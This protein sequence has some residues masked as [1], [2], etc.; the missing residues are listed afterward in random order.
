MARL[1]YPPVPN[2]GSLTVAT[3]TCGCTE[4]YYQPSPERIKDASGDPSNPAQYRKLLLLLDF[5][6]GYACMF[7]LCTLANGRFM[8]PKYAKIES[9]TVD[10]DF[11]AVP[12]PPCQRDVQELLDE[13]PSGFVK[14]FERGL[15]LLDAYRHIVHAVEGIQGVRHIAI[16]DDQDESLA[17]GVTCFLSA[18]RFDMLRRAFDRI[19][20]NSR[21]RV[22]L[23]K[24]ILAHNK[25]AHAFDKD[26]YPLRRLPYKKDVIY[27]LVTNTDAAIARLSKSD[28]DAAVALVRSQLPNIASRNAETLLRL[29]GD[30]ELVVLDELIA[31]YEEMMP[32][33]LSEGKWQ[34]FLRSN[35]FVLGLAFSVPIVLIDDQ[36]GV[37][38]ESV[39]G[40]GEK[41]TDFLV[42]SESTH[43]AALIEI[44]TPDT[45]LL[46]K[47]EYRGGVFAPTME[48]SGSVSQLLD[49]R[50]KFVE[51]LPLKMR[52]SEGVRIES[53]SVECILI[54]G[55]TPTDRSR[56]RSFEIFRRNSKDANVVTFDELLQKLKNLRDFLSLDV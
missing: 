7:P 4:V 54:I 28:Q 45:E 39:F 51:S 5:E 14:D 26:V 48:L 15:G 22:N 19:S 27:R 17:V 2:E 12:A 42:K 53:H 52:N 56:Q 8:E 30:I 34:K 46:Q 38:G 36:V 13:M 44:K 16:T 18:D 43:N 11:S 41:I 9:I 47:K 1:N 40:G 37:G 21:K 24:N 35:A 32:M 23:E 55:R 6:F 25:L 10:M 20:D 49:Q 29:R 31:K 3:G 33:K 50:G